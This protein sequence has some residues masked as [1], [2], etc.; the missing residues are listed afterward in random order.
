MNSHQRRKHRRKYTREVEQRI[1][2]DE[3]DNIFTTNQYIEQSGFVDFLFIGNLDGKKVVWNACMTTANGD[4]YE[5]VS[6]IAMDEAYVKFPNP[7]GYEPFNSVPYVDKDGNNTGMHEL[8]TQPEFK[9][10]TTTRYRWM[11]ERTMELLNAKQHSVSATQVEIDTSYKYGVGLH[12]RIDK[13][14]IEVDD[15]KKF[16]SDYN[17]GTYVDS[18]ETICLNATELGVEL[19]AD[20]QFVTWSRAFSHDTVAIKMDLTLKFDM[21]IN[22]L[23]SIGDITCHIQS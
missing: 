3:Y 19:C 16:I 21:S 18:D 13:Q 2:E 11:A 10:Y 15:V 1:L 23:K 4:Y 6:D 17:D 12:I 5:H 8:V 14:C 20:N 9:D 22:R 7:E